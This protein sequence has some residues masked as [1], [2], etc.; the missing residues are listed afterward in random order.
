MPTR[1]KPHGSSAPL[2]NLQLMDQ[3]IDVQ[4]LFEPMRP[5]ED[6]FQICQS[7]EQERCDQDATSDHQRRSD[8]TDE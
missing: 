7:E 5:N 2:A 4:G 3:L 6:V 8:H 1:P